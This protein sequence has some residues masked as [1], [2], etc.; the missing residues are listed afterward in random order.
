MIEFEVMVILIAFILLII[1]FI[2]REYVFAAISSMLMMATGI[3]IAFNGILGLNN[4]LSQAVA[5]C[6][7]G[8]G[9]FIFIKGGL[10]KIEEE[11]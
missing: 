5:I 7:I 2:F 4:F 11:G 8:V 1:A 6:L 9:A 3:Y 10:D